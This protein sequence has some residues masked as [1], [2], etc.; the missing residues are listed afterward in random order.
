MQRG[1][2][3]VEC[4]GTGFR[5]RAG[6]FEFVAFSDELREAIAARK[7]RTG[8]RAIAVR[9]GMVSLRLDGWE[10]ARR[11]LTTVEEVMRVTQE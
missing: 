1:A 5:G 10:K 11:G 2:G 4:R 8:L 6:L 7:S 9:G 3:C